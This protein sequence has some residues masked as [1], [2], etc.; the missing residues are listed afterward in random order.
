MRILFCFA[1][2]VVATVDGCGGA[3]RIEWIDT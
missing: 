2:L 3:I 1:A